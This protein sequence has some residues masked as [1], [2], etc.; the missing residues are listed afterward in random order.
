MQTKRLSE[1]GFNIG[2]LSKKNYEIFLT[3]R[4]KLKALKS[5]VKTQ[6][7]KNNPKILELFQK[8]KIST[9]NFSLE[10][11]LKKPQLKFSKIEEVL[12]QASKEEFNQ[13]DESIKEMVENDLKYSGYIKKQQNQ[14]KQYQK[15][16]LQKI[17]KGLDY[18]QIGGLSTEV[19]E[20]LKQYQPENLA[21]MLNISG[22]TPAAT[23]ILMIYLKSKTFVTANG[24]ES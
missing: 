17:P 4:K 9:T 21:Q 20:K 15:M 1:I 5:W 3:K 24:M 2:L 6:K 22:V 11:L 18:T 13:W 14:L 7:L 23:T 16:Q 8:E 10:S 19:K 12:L